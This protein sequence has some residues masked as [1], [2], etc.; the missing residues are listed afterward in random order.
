MKGDI[1]A[2]KV[3]VYGTSTCPWCTKT[4]QLLDENNIAYEDIDVTMNKEEFEIIMNETGWMTV[5]IIDIDGELA[6]GFS[7]K[8][9]KQKLELD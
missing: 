6:A 5:P 3:K 9:I 1:L 4:K 2:H 8:W 7:E